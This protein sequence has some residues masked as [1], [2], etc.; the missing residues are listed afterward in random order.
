MYE[1]KGKMAL[2]MITKRENYFILLAIMAF[3]KAAV[4]LMPYGCVAGF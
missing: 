4:H 3:I 1:I 2:W